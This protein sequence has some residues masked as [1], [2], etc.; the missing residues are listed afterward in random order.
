MLSAM[1]GYVKNSQIITESDIAK[2]EGMR[3][4]IT[5]LN[6]TEETKPAPIDFATYGHRTERG[7]NVDGYMTEMRGND[8]F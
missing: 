7:Q 8:R 5:F 6:E 4:V 1:H 3:L 2:F